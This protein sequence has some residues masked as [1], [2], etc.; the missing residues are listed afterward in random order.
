MIWDMDGTILDSMRYWDTLGEDYLIRK[1]IK[2]PAGINRTLEVMTLEESAAYLRR[3]MNIGLSEK[4][5]ISEILALIDTEYRNEIPAKEGAVKLI[6]AA[7][8]HGSR[9]CVLT[10]SDRALA[11]A[12]LRRVG[13]RDCFEA[14]LTS[15]DFGMD[16][17]SAAIYQR[18]MEEM[19]Y[20]PEQTLICEDALFAVRSAAESGA[21]VLAFRDSSNAGDWEQ[22]RKLADF[23]E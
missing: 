16:K 3:E 8:E 10:S 6:R 5:I 15:D 12:A 21:K 19:G 7:R 4:E 14:I 17:R 20:V 2:P 1:G 18:A 13:L 9:M 11:D 22:I 23:A